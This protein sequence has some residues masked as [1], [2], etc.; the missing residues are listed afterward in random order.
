MSK[1][2]H[3]TEKTGKSVQVSDIP[4]GTYFYCEIRGYST[5]K[6][7]LLLRTYEGMI[8]IDDPSNQWTDTKFGIDNYRP[9][10]MDLNLN[11]GKKLPRNR[12][13]VV[14]SVEKWGR[15]GKRD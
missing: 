8:D 14:R 7:H 10:V 1:V 6:T 9:A 4:V 3:L 5:I 13:K 15:V 11:L 2:I 12:K